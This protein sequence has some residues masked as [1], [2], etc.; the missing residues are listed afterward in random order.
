MQRLID[1][2]KALGLHLTD[3]QLA[4][5]QIYYEDLVT[6]NQKFN[7]TAI[8]EYNQVQIRHFLDSLSC[9]MAQEVQHILHRPSARVIDV[10]SGAGFPASPS[11]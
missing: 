10:G 4:A 1:G 9:L 7:L 11:N 8:T 3:K 2:A 5:F 6:W